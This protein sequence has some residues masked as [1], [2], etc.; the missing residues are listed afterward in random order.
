MVKDLAR[1]TGHSVNTV[2]FYI[3]ERLVQEFARSPYTN[4]RYFD[5]KSIDRL[6]KIR[7]LR[8]SGT[9]LKVIKSIFEQDDHA[10]SS[11]KV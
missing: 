4:F 3:R 8:R 11:L 9:P 7:D 5:E 10:S 1:T 2:K 6:M